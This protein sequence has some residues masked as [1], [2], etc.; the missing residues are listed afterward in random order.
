M[1]GLYDFLSSCGGVFSGKPDTKDG[2]GPH[3]WG[4]E[5]EDALVAEKT[6][7]AIEENVEA[8]ESAEET[9]PEVEA[10]VVPSVFTLDEFMS[11][12]SAARAN[13]DLFGA[14]S[15]RTVT[16]SDLSGLKA[17]TSASDEALMAANA[18][19]KNGGKAKKEKD[20]RSANAVK[21]D[22]DIKFAAAE[23]PRRERR[24][25][26]DRGRGSGRGAGRGGRGAGRGGRGSDRSPRAASADLDLSSQ[27]AFP[28][29]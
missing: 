3:G 29:L 25:D 12:R 16:A 7:A 21:L 22:I 9:T 2:A 10:P 19:A 4:N 6:N 20:Q 24:E 15:E 8:V 5:S 26:N 11:R 1:I 23:A 28:S 14:V 18:L 27:T 13:S 17:K